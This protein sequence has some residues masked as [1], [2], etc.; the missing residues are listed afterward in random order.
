M[1]LNSYLLSVIHGCQRERTGG[2][3]TGGLIAVCRCLAEGLARLSENA[4][5]D[6][7]VQSTL[8]VQRNVPASPI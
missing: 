1:P 6:G 3:A 2:R 8:N 7:A 4:G 5:D